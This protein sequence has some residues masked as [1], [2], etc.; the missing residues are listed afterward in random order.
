MDMFGNQT[1]LVYWGRMKHDENDR[2]KFIR[3][4]FKDKELSQILIGGVPSGVKRDYK[5]IT[6]WNLLFG[7]LTESR[8]TLC[9]NWKDP[10]ATTSRYIEALA[11][12]LI[13]FVL[14]D[15]YINNT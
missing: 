2:S 11:I 5:W 9:F 12:G 6:D 15:Y 1:D 7:I 3:K 10:T 13:S 14:K 8:S 4:V